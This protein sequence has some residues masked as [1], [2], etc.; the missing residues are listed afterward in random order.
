[1]SLSYKLLIL[2]LSLATASTFGAEWQ[3]GG[4]FPPPE[5]KGG[6]RKLDAAHEIRRSAGMDP[7]ELEELRQWLL[8]SDNRNFAAVVIRRGHIVLVIP[9]WFVDETAKPTHS[10]IG[11]EMRFKINAR[12]FSHSWELP[13]CLTG[14]NS[15]PSGHGIP[16]DAR[17]RP[18]SGGQLIAFVPGL[19]LVVTRQIGSSG[20]WQYAEYLRRACAAVLSEGKHSRAGMDAR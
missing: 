5:S 17:Y 9:K 20:K 19:D 14:E 3:E 1:M 8:R 13:A 4:Y 6:W 15:T 10:V 7:Q 18:G 2:V 11:P 12:T 16:E